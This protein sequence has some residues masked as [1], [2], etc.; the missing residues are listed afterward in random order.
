MST[1]MPTLG[2]L[3][4]SGCGSECSPKITERGMGSPNSD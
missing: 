2:K 3:T 4:T 1:A